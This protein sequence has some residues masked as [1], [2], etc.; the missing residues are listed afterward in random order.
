MTTIIYPDKKPPRDPAVVEQVIRR[1]MPPA[2]PTVPWQG[3][4]LEPA[5]ADGQPYDRE[6]N[7]QD[8]DL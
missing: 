6:D 3:L 1:F 5:Y 4:F 8:A 7:G 2:M